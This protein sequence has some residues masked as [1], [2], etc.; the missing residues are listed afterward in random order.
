MGWLALVFLGLAI[1]FVVEPWGEVAPLGTN[2]EVDTKFASKQTVRDPLLSPTLVKSTFNYRCNECHRIFDRAVNKDVL[3]AEHTD[4]Q[5]DHGANSKCFNCHNPDDLETLRDYEGT[6]VDFQASE[7]LCRSCHGPKY[8][9]WVAG[10]HG[11]PNGYW[12][13]TK[14]DSVKA[15]CVQ[16]HD[17]HSPAFKPIAPAPAPMERNQATRNPHHG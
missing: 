5:L 9:D 1:L 13:P 12:D 16:C 2:P 7:Q 8:R 10:A 15:T 6:L 3:I 4:I 14:G 17:P 11:R